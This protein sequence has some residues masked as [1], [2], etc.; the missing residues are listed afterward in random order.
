MAFNA[1]I[2]RHDAVGDCVVNTMAKPPLSDRLRD[3]VLSL[4][5]LE[6]GNYLL[7][8]IALPYLVRTLGAEHFGLMVFAQAFIQ[9]FVVITEYGF[10]KSATRD[11]ARNRERSEEIAAI[12]GSVMLA[13]AGLAVVSLVFL[14]ALVAAVPLFRADWEL[15]ALGFLAV[16][17][18]VLFPVWLFQGME[19]MKY[20]T[21]L[22]LGA[23]L[24][25]VVALFLFVHAPD[26][27]RLALAIQAGA[28][29]LGGVASLV[30]AM[31]MLGLRWKT[32]STL[33]IKTRL[34]AGWHYFLSVA[35]GSL[36]TDGAIF[37]LGLVANPTIAGYFTAAYKLV[38]AAVRLPR[39]LIQ[40]FYPR[41]NL[42]AATSQEDALRF[43]R[44][45]IRWLMPAS[46][47]LSLSIYL[48]AE[49]VIAV[50]YG[51]AFAPAAEV[52]RWMAPLPFLI[53]FSN[54][55][56]VQIMLSFGLE[57]QYSRI[58]LSC[59]FLSAL[60]LFPLGY[61]WGAIGAALGL[62]ITE[63]AILL[64]II[65]YLKASG[66]SFLYAK[67]P[68]SSQREEVNVTGALIQSK[69][70]KMKKPDFFIIGAPKCGTTAL[71]EYLRMHPRVFFSDPK[72]PSYFNHDFARRDTPTLTRYLDYFR[73]ADDRYLAVGE[74]S[75]S[76]L[77]SQTA[78][79]E[80]LHFNPDARFIVMLRNPIEMVPA[81]HAQVL[82]NGDEDQW[83]FARAWRLQ[84]QR[85]AN[86]CIP[87]LCRD[88]KHLWYGDYGLLGRQLERL[89]SL[90]DRQRV[91]I[92]LFEDFTRD[93]AAVYNEVLEFLGLPAHP[94][95]NFQPVNRHRAVRSPRLHLMMR[96]LSRIKQRLIGRYSLGVTRLYNKVNTVERPREALSAELAAEL[97]AYFREDVLKLSGLLGRDLTHWLGP[98]SS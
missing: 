78:V 23:R 10:N 39:P 14:A 77:F 32:P 38:Y 21:C 1:S 87:A 19:R 86:E 16:V 81:L 28:G 96:W 76:Y 27:Y 94:G 56:G 80:I 37:I 54:M 59:G 74:G 93:P 49:P 17:G 82:L 41:V 48:L 5:A 55:L 68:Q 9:L 67:K 45:A 12:F 79:P 46:L 29:V 13:K 18:N 65:S 15:Y 7:P 66:I 2:V 91:K 35:A 25:G 95:R 36:Y 61:A 85:K 62:V 20:I 72:E 24:I 3:N 44:R 58:V 84:E 42:L 75:T 57:R 98:R 33:Q 50:L 43:I 97:R 30:V 73:S 88:P 92:I 34:A 11:I 52:M 63:V 53:T 6:A 90:V 69:D 8:L 47:A 40:A 89:L 51:A 31:T 60:A 71:S 64:A 26:D 4:S 22:N 83:D 70:T